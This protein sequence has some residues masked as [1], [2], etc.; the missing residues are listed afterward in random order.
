MRLQKG[1]AGE[2]IEVTPKYL[3]VPP[4]LETLAERQLTQIQAVALENVNTFSFLSLVVEPRLT[5]QI[6]W[7]LAADTAAIEGIEYAYLEGEAGPQTFSEVGFARDGMSFK[8]REDFGAA[9]IEYRGLYKNPG[10]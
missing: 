9:I 5:S 2:P 1:L 3:V 6:A 10:A 4:A 8:I 7:Y